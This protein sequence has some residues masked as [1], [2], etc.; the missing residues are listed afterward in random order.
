MMSDDERRQGGGDGDF[1]ETLVSPLS[2]LTFYL[3]CFI[4]NN[5][6]DG[7]A[8]IYKGERRTGLLYLINL[9]GPST[10]KSIGLLPLKSPTIIFS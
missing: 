6:N 7:L 9:I 1:C 8:T 3:V 5:A 2:P 10:I 4:S